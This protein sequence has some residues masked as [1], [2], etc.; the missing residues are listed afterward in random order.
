[1][2]TIYYNGLVFTGALPL[3]QAFSVRDGR[4]AAVGSQEDVLA[5]VQ[6][7]DALVD[8]RGRFACPGF[9]DSHMHLLGYGSNRE[10]CALSAHT[11]SLRDMQE[12][13]RAF[14]ASRPWPEEA[15]IRGRGFNEDFFAEHSGLPTRHDLDAV[16]TRYPVCVVRCCGHCLVVNTR[17]LTLLGLDGTQPQPAGGHYDVDE[18]GF[19]TGVFRDNAMSM[20]YACLPS[21]TRADIGRMLRDACASLNRFGITSVHTD[22]LRTFE[23]VDYREVLA[24]Y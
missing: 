12:A 3:V 7:G 21:P 10:C 19:P 9:N 22:D 8:L 2:Q 17:A 24:A 16:T 18:H 13:L 6:E 11:S 23:N 4:F 1:M 14:A 20:V 15:W 5:T